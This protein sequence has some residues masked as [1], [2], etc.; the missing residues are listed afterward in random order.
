MFQKHVKKCLNIVFNSQ[1]RKMSRA[2]KEVRFFHNEETRYCWSFIT[3]TVKFEFQ[4]HSEESRTHLRVWAPCCESRQ[5]TEHAEVAQHLVGSLVNLA[6]QK[7]EDDRRLKGYWLSRL[8]AKWGEG[9]LESVGVHV[10]LRS[11]GTIQW[12]VMGGTKSLR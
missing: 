10:V 11:G 8:A 6:A 7:A 3:Y 1:L 4:I 9:G 5:V 12:C 2:A